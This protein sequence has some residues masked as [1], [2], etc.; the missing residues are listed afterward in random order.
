MASS[1]ATRREWRASARVVA[2]VFV[3]IFVKVRNIAGFTAALRSR[4]ARRERSGPGHVV[5]APSRHLPLFEGGMKLRYDN[6]GHGILAALSRTS[7]RSR[8]VVA[9]L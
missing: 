8:A 4:R 1:G 2:S 7:R 9:T 6:V 5:A 3:R